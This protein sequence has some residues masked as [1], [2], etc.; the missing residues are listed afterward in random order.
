M[1]F[2]WRLGNRDRFVTNLACNQ[3]RSRRWNGKVFVALHLA[4]AFFISCYFRKFDCAQHILICHSSYY[5]FPVCSNIYITFWRWC[6]CLKSS[7]HITNMRQISNISRAL[8]GYEFVD[9]L[10]VVGQSLLQLHLHYWLNTWLQWI[11]HI[12]LQDQTRNIY[13]WG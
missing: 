5:V 11:G 6:I 13:V 12:H 1:Y 4:R 9:N 10:D 8:V 3:F 7:F 2:I